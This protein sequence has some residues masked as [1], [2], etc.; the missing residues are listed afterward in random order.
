MFGSIISVITSFIP[1]FSAMV[2]VHLIGK[3]LLLTLCCIRMFGTLTPSVEA[4]E[5]KV[6]F[7]Y[8]NLQ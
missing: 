1:L 8:L 5:L 6:V 2:Q 7:A 4:Y 3:V